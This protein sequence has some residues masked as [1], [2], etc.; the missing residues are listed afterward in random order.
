MENEC[1]EPCTAADGGRY[2]CPIRKPFELIWEECKEN[3]PRQC[4][5]GQW[6]CKDKC[7]DQSDACENIC[8][9]S[10]HLILTILNNWQQ[11]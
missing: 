7:I 5:P 2:V 11:K 6:K 8:K 1:Y 4:L 3:C 10:K 9:P